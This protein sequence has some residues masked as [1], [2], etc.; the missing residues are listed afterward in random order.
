VVVAV[1][2]LPNEALSVSTTLETFSG[3]SVRLFNSAVWAAVKVT[4]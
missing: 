4:G 2:A 1:S 3:E